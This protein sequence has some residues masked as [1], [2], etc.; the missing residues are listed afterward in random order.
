M[1]EVYEAHAVKSSRIKNLAL[2][3]QT[4][5]FLVSFNFHDPFK[6]GKT[7]FPHKYINKRTKR[8]QSWARCSLGAG[9]HKGKK[10]KG[11]KER[12]FFWQKYRLFLSYTH[13]WD[14]VVHLNLPPRD[15]LGVKH[16]NIFFFKK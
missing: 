6:S 1:N 14:F 3:F 13:R 7:N 12:L 11:T 8:L 16:E 15:E 2:F 5:F 4:E 9:P 10:Q